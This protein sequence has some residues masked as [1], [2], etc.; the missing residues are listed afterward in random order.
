MKPEI[1]ER[2]L[3]ALRSGKYRQGTGSLC[4]VNED[5]QV[6]YCCLGVL[7]ELYIQEHEDAK[8][9]PMGGSSLS[10][11]GEAG[12]LHEDIRYWSGILATNPMVEYNNERETLSH[13]NDDY[14]CDFNR[15]ADLIEESL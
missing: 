1:K 4:Y 11:K 15:I 12:V 8:W 3:K 13:C 14:G 6:C 5:E 10:Y 2:W 9:S 7:T